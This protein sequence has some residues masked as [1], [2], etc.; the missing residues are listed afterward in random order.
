MVKVLSDTVEGTYGKVVR[1]SIPFMSQDLK[2]LNRD[3]EDGRLKIM[4]SRYNRGNYN[5]FVRKTDER[6]GFLI[7]YLLSTI[8]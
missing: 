2:L 8:T 3:S 5:S 4:K 7:E 1:L 6:N